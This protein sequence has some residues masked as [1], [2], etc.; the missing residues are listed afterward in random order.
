MAVVEID[1]EH[2]E[3]VVARGDRAIGRQHQTAVED[4]AVRRSDAD[5]ANQDPGAMLA[6]PSGHGGDRGMLRFRHCEGMKHAVLGIEPGAIFRQRDEARALRRGLV[7]EPAQNAEIGFD[8]RRCAVLY[9]GGNEFLDHAPTLS[10]PMALDQSMATPHRRNK[11][12]TARTIWRSAR[13]ARQTSHSLIVGSQSEKPQRLEARIGNDLALETMPMPMPLATASRAASRLSISIASASDSPRRAELI[14]QQRARG[15][16]LLAQDDRKLDEF[17]EG[18]VVAPG[19]ADGW[20]RRRPRS[21]PRAAIATI[22]LRSG[23]LADNGEIDL[24][25]IELRSRSSAELP[26]IS[27]TAIF[28]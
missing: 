14:E 26:A 16:A 8:I 5:R 24:E 25:A 19:E 3:L 20:R 13:A 21:R 17:G 4:A 28:G 15:R 9:A 11:A 7:D 12:S 22:G 10:R 2:M 6:R 23:P 1:I 18:D 27:F